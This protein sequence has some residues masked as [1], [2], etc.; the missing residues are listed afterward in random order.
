MT[1]SIIPFIS[2]TLALGAALST[3]DAR[4]DRAADDAA[5]KLAKNRKD[6]TFGPEVSAICVDLRQRIDENRWKD[7]VK[8]TADYPEHAKL[9]AACFDDALRASLGIQDITNT[10]G[11]ML[12][13]GQA[14]DRLV[15]ECYRV[16]DKVHGGNAW[17]KPYDEMRGRKAFVATVRAKIEEDFKKVCGVFARVDGEGGVSIVLEKKNAKSAKSAKVFFQ[18]KDPGG[19]TLTVHCSGKVVKTMPGGGTMQTEARTEADVARDAGEWACM[20]KCA[21]TSLACASSRN[22]TESTCASACRQQCAQ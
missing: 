21:K 11:D 9:V 5:W 19:D 2:I 6:C 12:R 22:P 1:R 4:A 17:R 16:T 20:E 13:T 15:A 7:D 14:E 18:G 3:T 8:H 10:A